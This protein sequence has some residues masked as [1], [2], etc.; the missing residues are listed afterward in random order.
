M[1]RGG[2]MN[3]MRMV[4]SRCE[5]SSSIFWPRRL[6]VC[7]SAACTIGR[8][9]DVMA[10]AQAGGSLACDGSG[11]VTTLTSTLT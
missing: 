6:G 8:R 9:P 4:A 2:Q 10:H 5:M 7:A 3:F 11:F 1:S